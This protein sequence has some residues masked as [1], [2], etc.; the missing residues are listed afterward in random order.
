MAT[1]DIIDYYA[2]LLILQYRGLPK[3]YAMVQAFAGPVIMNQLGVQAQNAFDIGTAIG[4]QLDVLGQYVGVSR[5][6][7]NFSGAVTLDDDDFRL[8][9]QI[10][11]VL[12]A[13]T[14]DLESIQNFLHTYFDG[15][16][17]V[18]DYRN[19]TM[20]YV[21]LA[22]IG[23]NNVAEVLVQSGLLPKPTGVLLKPTVYQPTL[24]YFFGFRTAYASAQKNVGFNT[25][26]D[27]QMNTPWLSA[28]SV[29]KK[30]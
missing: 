18:F 27:Y 4:A 20:D 25:V 17:Q 23:S 22:L 10:K 12:N 21:Y 13:L 14:S 28:K 5:N 7:F 11:V 26:A 1:S 29:I 15:V 24:N 19:M 9:I 30:A 6:T 8:L 2:D 3:A 16:L